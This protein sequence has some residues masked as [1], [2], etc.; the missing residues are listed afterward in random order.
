[1][2]FLRGLVVL[3]LGLG[4]GL[5]LG[6]CEHVQRLAMP[7]YQKNHPLGIFHL[8]SGDERVVYL[9]ID[10]GPSSLTGELLDLM[11]EFGAT[12]TMFLHTD[13]ITDEAILHRAIEAGHNLGHHM[14]ADRDWS[15]D[16]EASV[17]TGFR[18]SHC[19]LVRF[20]EGYTGHFRPPLGIF[21][22]ATML[23]SLEAAGMAGD[24]A[25][26]M[27]SLAPWDAGGITEGS[28]GAANRF[29]ARRY[30]GGLG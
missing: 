2:R 28:W 1:M 10:D 9:T 21:N 3:V 5:S 22:K 30:G 16:S 7:E 24:K 25:Y 20:G 15:E 29:W 18:E 8:P 26:V 14:P 11:G 27:G 12:S 4:L 23:P 6:G 17:R 13:H 19:I